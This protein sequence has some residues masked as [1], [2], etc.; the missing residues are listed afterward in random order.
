MKRHNYCPK[1]GSKLPQPDPKHCPNCGAAI[2]N[3]AANEPV[4]K[5]ETAAQQPSSANRNQNRDWSI[6][7]IVILII[8]MFY[9]ANSKWGNPFSDLIPVPTPTPSPGGGILDGAT[10]YKGPRPEPG[11]ISYFNE[12]GE[13][14]TALALPGELLVRAPANSKRA[15]VDRA[16]RATGVGYKVLS[17]I[18]VIGSYLIEVAPGREAYFINVLRML[19]SGYSAVPNVVLSATAASLTR[20]VD[21]SDKGIPPC[22]E[23]LYDPIIID[24]PSRSDKVI[25]ALIDN[26]DRENPAE[27]SHGDD[28]GAALDAY[29]GG[30]PVLKLNLGHD[31]VAAD[32]IER[33]LASAVAV[34][35]RTGQDVV[36]SLS[37]GPSTMFNAANKQDLLDYANAVARNARG[38]RDWETFMK[39]LLNVLANSEW[40]KTGHV[41]LH[42]SAD[43]GALLC[44]PPNPAVKGETL[45]SDGAKI[46]ED[47]GIDL[48]EPMERLFKDMVYGPLM[49]NN[50]RVWCAFGPGTTTPADY[51][52][53][54]TGIECREPYNNLRGTSFSAPIGAG[55]DYLAVKE[56]LAG[57]GPPIP[58][59][60]PS[61]TP[62]CA[63]TPIITATATPRPTITSTISPARDLTGKWVGSASFIEDNIYG[64]AASG[65]V[66]CSWSGT[67]T[68]DLI[69][70]GNNIRGYYNKGTAT[71]WSSFLFK[72]SDHTQTIKSQ[73]G[74]VPP[75]GCYV[76]EGN[77]LDSGIDS[78]TVSSSS[79][80][81]ST[82][83]RP[84]FSGSFTS[85]HM[86]LSLTNC[87]L[88]AGD[89]CTVVDGAKWKITLVRQTG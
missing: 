13:N 54:G 34:A 18:P 6:P 14:E 10:F 42:K 39:V 74:E 11:M 84:T 72:I 20:I 30:C 79:I 3:E 80:Q 73:T 83:G 22:G 17:A 7:V 51:S 78:G 15:D 35:E 65:E 32:V 21:L 25:T 46:K 16:L 37:F 40:A 58:R 67:F 61:V 5:T 75:A 66:L 45:C 77:V 2:D 60:S 44:D 59:P 56:R 52:N 4:T 33:S 26:F 1:C 28:T 31:Q 69:Q 29:C 47:I 9:V 53:Y 50:V 64:G 87:L 89:S 19:S 82:G 12:R 57:S 41:R 71:T 88:Q 23:G 36:V 76:P 55:Y 62:T 85:D 81:M 24:S 43:N 49:R 68:F 86:S 8:A 48:T 38:G 70:N 63:P 27:R